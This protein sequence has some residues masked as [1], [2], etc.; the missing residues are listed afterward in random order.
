VYKKF[1]SQERK[2]RERK[3]ERET[4]KQTNKREGRKEGR[5][6][7]K[8]KERRKEKTY[9]RFSMKGWKIYFKKW[10][11]KTSSTYIHI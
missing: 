6:K 5:K 11:L 10:N 9:H 1:T 7:R 4:N 2:E 8:D 3:R